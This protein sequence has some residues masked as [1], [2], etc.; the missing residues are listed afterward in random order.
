MHPNERARQS[1]L[2]ALTTPPASSS[3]P[4]RHPPPQD[5]LAGIHGIARRTLRDALVVVNDVLVTA[6]LPRVPAFVVKVLT[7]AEVHT[8]PILEVVVGGRAG[9]HT[10]TVQVEVAAGHTLSGVVRFR[11]VA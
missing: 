7:E 5:S 8:A 11:T 6:R 3:F 1:S 9:L 10:P 4:K 2:T